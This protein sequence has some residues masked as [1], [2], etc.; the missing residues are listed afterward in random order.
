MA[1][2]AKTLAAASKVCHLT[3][4]SRE[5]IKKAEETVKVCGLALEA[6]KVAADAAAVEAAKAAKAAAAEAAKKAEEDRL[7]R[8][9]KEAQMEGAGAMEM[10]K[11]LAAEAEDA[12]AAAD[13]ALVDH[14]VDD[15]GQ[16]AEPTL[17][18]KARDA[19][20]ASADA[21]Q[22]CSAAAAEMCK[23]AED[24]DRQSIAG[25]GAGVIHGCDLEG[26]V[27]SLR[28]WLS[29]ALPGDAG[30]AAQC[31]AA[32]VA[33]GLGSLP[34]PGQIFDKAYV[35][36]AL[37]FW[38]DLPVALEEFRRVLDPQG[39]LVLALQCSLVAAGQW[40]AHLPSG[41]VWNELDIRQ[42]LREAGFG[43]Q[44]AKRFV[45][46]DETNA[47]D[48]D[49]ATRQEKIE[50][51]ELTQQQQRAANERNLKMAPDC[52]IEYVGFACYRTVYCA[53]CRVAVS[54][55]KSMYQPVGANPTPNAEPSYALAFG[56]TSCECLL[57]ILDDVDVD[58]LQLDV[59]HP[60][61]AEGDL[62]VTHT[63]GKQEFPPV[64]LENHHTPP[65][66]D[67]QFTQ[68]N[69]ENLM[70]TL[71]S[72][73]RAMHVTV[74]AYAAEL[75][76]KG[77]VTTRTLLGGG[78]VDL[79]ELILKLD[80]QGEQPDSYA[81]EVAVQA[82]DASRG[83]VVKVVVEFRGEAQAWSAAFMR[84]L[85]TI[86]YPAHEEVNIC[87]DC[88]RMATVFASQTAAIADRWK[89]KHAELEE[90]TADTEKNKGSQGVALDYVILVAGP[91]DGR[92]SAARAMDEANLLSANFM[93][94]GV[95]AALR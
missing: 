94:A 8:E 91:L 48:M 61:G 68:E 16:I 50:R 25:G 90:M 2:T 88:Y 5:R 34:F 52:T 29:D 37:S 12:E 20:S 54:S 76:Y 85:R 36:G 70:K 42:A 13:T 3:K 43:I 10:L 56:P 26:R 30:D 89:T 49:E 9:A 74:K 53:T 1:K 15:R 60:W 32:D 28:D 69:T 78:T 79:G 23:A 58:E 22:V 31:C 65:V 46:D 92:F 41:V 55:G 7:K 67:F 4:P 24:L 84:R 63:F 6:A 45:L 33:G 19:A 57:S 82:T 27:E 44:V 40:K 81:F 38:P 35:I 51:L 59:S 95:T 11:I 93:R 77:D 62:V 87:R 71:S 80:T 64:D 18:E 17:A 66:Y 47:R 21:G 75:D 86:Y 73:R 83:P 72:N 39:S 14:A